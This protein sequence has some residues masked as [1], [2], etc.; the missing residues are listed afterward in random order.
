[1][2]TTP[3]AGVSPFAGLLRTL[4]QCDSA[5][6]RTSRRGCG[7]TPDTRSQR[8]SPAR[9][10]TRSRRGI[11]RTRRRRGNRALAPS[12]DIGRRLCHRAAPPSAGTASRSTSPLNTGPDVSVGSGSASNTSGTASWPAGSPSSPQLPRPSMT[13]NRPAVRY[14]RRRRR[15]FRGPP[16]AAKAT[17]GGPWAH[18]PR[19]ARSPRPVVTA[20]CPA[21]SP[22]LHR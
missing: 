2:T 9:P 7:G 17:D 16:R 13:T 11:R 18:R 14:D 1:V 4:P 3:P 15:G 19:R 22:G 8:R 12:H 21:V 6:N 20:G 5:C 10:G